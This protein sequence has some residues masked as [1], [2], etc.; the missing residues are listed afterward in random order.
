MLSFEIGN[1]FPPLEKDSMFIRVTRG[2][3]WNRCIFC[4]SYKNLKFEI[5]KIEDIL[6]D[7]DIIHNFQNTTDP[8]Y[9]STFSYDIAVK[10]KNAKRIFLQDCDVLSIKHLN[11]ILDA[12]RRKT[13]ISNFSAYS[14]LSNLK[15]ATKEIFDSGLNKLYI[16]LET[17]CQKTLKLINKQHKSINIEQVIKAKRIGY[18]LFIH[19][20]VGIG[21]TELSKDNALE[22]AKFINEINPYAVEVRTTIV[23][24]NTKLN[25]MKNCDKWT[26]LTD[27]QKDEELKL[28]LE[29]L[30][31]D[32]FIFSNHSCNRY[33]HFNGHFKTNKQDFLN[34]L[35]S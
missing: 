35:R 33:Q 23:F 17:G 8:Y 14:S 9:I 21:G 18:K 20:I 29:T 16:G 28:F 1:I 32:G 13:K 31:F 11:E 26:E 27:I 24:K 5:R 12:I 22:T 10:W 2:C 34:Q 15:Y 30:D 6:K 7:I 4:N 3:S 25:K 19:Y